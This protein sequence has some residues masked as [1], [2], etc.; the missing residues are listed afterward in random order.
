MSLT[1]MNHRCF[2]LGRCDGELVFQKQT[3]R[4][5]TG[6]SETV[7][8]MKN[9]CFRNSQYDGEP[10]FQKQSMQW[11][12]VVSEKVGAMVFQTMSVCLVL[13]I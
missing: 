2:R 8:A 11:R 7:G 3:G 12:T 4:W 9:R 5:R 1:K 10:V 13:K 6:V